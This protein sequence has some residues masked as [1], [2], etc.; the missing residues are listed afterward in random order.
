MD[1]GVRFS[2]VLRARPRVYRHL[3]RTPLYRYPALDAATGLRLWVKHENHQPVGA[4]KVRGGVN[5]LAALDEDE[6]R[7]G[8]VAASTG[9]HG[10]SVAYAA[11][12]YGV[13]AVVFVPEGANPAKVAAMRGLGAEVVARGRDFD[14]ARRAAEAHA[15][16]RGMRFIDSGDEPL[17]IAGVATYALEILEDNPEIEVVLVP[18]GGGSGAAGTAIVIKTLAPQVEV[19]GVQSEAAPAAYLSWKEGRA[20]EVPPRTFAEGLATGSPFALPQRI[21]RALLDDFLLVPEDAIAAAIRLYLAHAHSLAEGAGA[22]ALAAAVHH[23]QRF[24]GR[25]VAVVLSG[26][27][28]SLTQ[29]R[30]LLDVGGT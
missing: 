3:P 30:R 14:A 5:L 18:V 28:L 11:R 1:L 6:R 12:L 8:V 20:V 19:I 29:L 15:R 23:R 9:N 16:D 22:A 25:R 7:G 2:D 27:N 13:P 10:Q 24:L 21:L 17:L 4:F 26:G